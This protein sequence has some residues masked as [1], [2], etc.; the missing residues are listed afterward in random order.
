MITRGYFIGE[1]VDGLGD[2]ARQAEVRAKLGLTDLHIFVEDFFKKCLNHLLKLQ[3]TNLNIDRHNEPGLDLGDAGSGRAFQITAQRS[4]TKIN[5][6]LKKI[7][8]DH[9]KTF[10]KVQ[11][12]I[13][14]RK[15]SSYT[16]DP[17]LC[18]RFGFE[19]A[20]IWDVD[21]LCKLAMNL[22]LPDLQSL[23]EHVRRETAKVKIELEVPDEDGKYPTT[24]FDRVEAVPKARNSD[25]ARLAAV[26][27]LVEYGTTP[28]ELQVA[29]NELASAL[30][31]LP[32]VTREFLSVLVEKRDEPSGII[33]SGDNFRISADR[34][35]RILRYDDIDGELRIL[36]DHGLVAEYEPGWEGKSA[37]WRVRFPWRKQEFLHLIVNDYLEAAGIP[38]RRV[39]VDLDFSVFGDTSTSP[40]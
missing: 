10:P 8:D 18:A 3:L 5:E 17:Q 24:L 35:P 20:D 12:L 11:V 16:L 40:A 25:F 34:L 32:R 6:T 29:F 19:E 28:G 2:I 21:E 33:G 1:I 37:F 22:D 13:V 38:W 7:T 27:E 30:G 14:G 26:P 31:K 23:H 4:S 9:L 39:L 36:E 15:Q